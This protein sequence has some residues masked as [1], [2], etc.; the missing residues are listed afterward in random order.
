MLRLVTITFILLAGTTFAFGQHAGESLIVPEKR[1]G[2]IQA[3]AKELLNIIPDSTIQQTSVNVIEIENDIRLSIRILE[4]GWIDLSGGN[5]IYI[6]TTSS[7][8]NPEIGDVSVAIDNRKNVYYNE[9][10]VCGGIIHF[11]TMQLRKLKTSKE[12]FASFISDTDSMSWKRL[13]K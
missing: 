4:E 10:H 5:W 11:E 7:H 12:F 13:K 8:N 9:G 2:W 1:N 3:T 6:I